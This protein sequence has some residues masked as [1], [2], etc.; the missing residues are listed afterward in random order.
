MVKICS[1]TY[2]EED[3]E[4]YKEYYT[5]FPYELAPFQKHAIQGLVEGNHVLVTA[6]TGSGKSTCFQFAAKYFVEKGKKVIYCSPIKSLSNQQFYEVS[7]K[8]PDISVGIITGDIRVNQD[9]SV[10]IV[11]TEILH[12]ILFLKK[13]KI[14]DESIPV[15]ANLLSFDMDFDTELGCVIFDEFHYINNPDRG[16][17]WENTIMMLPLHIQI[18]MLSATL[19]APNKIATWVENREQQENREKESSQESNKKQVYIASTTHRAVPLMHYSF[20]TT[21]Q[22]IFKAIKK[23]KELEKEINNNINKL[24]LIQNEKGEFNDITY[25]KIQKMLNLFENKQIYVK[26][27]HVVN[28]VCKHMVEN[29]LLPAIC[30]VLNK[31][32]LE[33]LAN[34]I[35]IPLLEDDSK[36]GYIL[37][38]ESEQIL[39]KLPNY[40][41]YLELPEY[42]NLVALMEKGI[43]LHHASMHSILKEM[44]ELFLSKGYIKLLFCT[45]TF[46]LGVN[47]PIKTVLF[48]NMTKFDGSSNRVLQP[49]EYTQ[50]SGR[51]G[52]KGLDKVGT[53]IHLNNLFSKVELTEYKQMMHGEPQK[54]VSK[55]KISYNLLLNLIDVGQTD[56][57]EFCKG[58]MIQNDIDSQT[59][60][61][62]IQMLE[63][64]TEIENLAKI[65]LQNPR[66]P[67]KTVQRYIE[68]L[69]IKKTAVNKKRKEIDREIE[70]II[71]TYKYITVDM[72]SI[73]KYNEKTKELEQINRQK[74]DAENYLKESIDIIIRFLEKDGFLINQSNQP[75]LYELTDRGKMATQLR[76][77][78]CLSISKLIESGQI[79]KLSPK[80]LV[81]IFSCFANIRVNDEQKT[82]LPNS[83]DIEV[84][85]IIKEINKMYD[86]YID[87]ETETQSNTGCDYEIQYDLIDYMLDWCDCTTAHECKIILNRL[88][89]EKGIFLGEFVKAI[90]KIN[91]ICSEMEKIAENMGNIE[92]LNK[93]N[94]IPK[95]TQKFVATN[96][97]LYV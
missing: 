74:Y 49:H 19:D 64:I 14:M 82:I 47:F 80:Q 66:T 94:E 56:L 22:G 70:Q 51:S 58:S 24:Q 93:L 96:Q 37:R 23:D 75:N 38:R 44:V 6:H 85:H 39:R 26:R 18:L 45:E 16:M 65:S 59:K 95:M 27:S 89:N 30:F 78:H 71:D 1:N 33:T 11:T 73:I 4:I 63:L 40:E 50:M 88:E 35:T 31:K 29:N 8:F 21:N 97:S 34:E 69:E 52:R 5:D 68:C 60:S 42:L 12:N 55:F 54:L 61:I 84:K 72:N 67:I 46:A 20:I 53:V 92:F 10:L 90:M 91:N 87:F 48:T 77:V 86:E 13:H 17:V 43:G 3:S 7:R 9:A 81:S 28:Q 79:V 41:E 83:K 15:P 76:E 32:Q 36:V 62:Q 57:L 25:H 2:P